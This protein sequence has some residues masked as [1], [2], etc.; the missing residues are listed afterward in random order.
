MLGDRN[1]KFFHTQTTVR[2]KH[3][4]VHRL[5]LPNG[6]QCND[7][8]IL[9]TKAVWYFQSL[10]CSNTQS[11]GAVSYT[12]SRNMP[13]LDAT[14]CNALIQEVTYDGITMALNQMHP[15]KSPGPDG[16]QG[17]FFTQYWN[18]IGEDI[19]NL[20]NWHVQCG[21]S[22]NLDIVDP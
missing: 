16:F 8:V 2:W 3:N 12:R 10:F 11:T 22:R 18:L 9:Q 17:V 7:D 1:T 4:K 5:T 6:I 19:S 15:F 21:Y 20:Q 14:M 13:G